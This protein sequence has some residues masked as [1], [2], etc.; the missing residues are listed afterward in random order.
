MLSPD[1]ASK[2]KPASA[3]ASGA[4]ESFLPLEM[5]ELELSLEGYEGGEPGFRET[6]RKAAEAAGGEL[7]FDL[8]AAG[9]MEDCI[10][11]GV[12]RVPQDA[13]K[14][15]IVLA[16]LDENGGEIRVQ[17]PNDNTAHLVRFADAFVAVIRQM[18]QA[19]PGV[20]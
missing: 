16:A 8:P 7:L 20:M 12:L 6:V 10:R 4:S 11:L 2:A 9:L 19:A 13:D 18:P 17:L 5:L 15:R 14:T 1:T 3:G